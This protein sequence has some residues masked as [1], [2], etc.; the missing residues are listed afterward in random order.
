M[1]YVQVDGEEDLNVCPTELDRHTTEYSDSLLFQADIDGGGVFTARVSTFDDNV[2]S[3]QTV[4]T[5]VFK[6]RFTANSTMDGIALGMGHS[7]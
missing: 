5:D 1:F 4:I 7:G 2:E 3:A 6:N